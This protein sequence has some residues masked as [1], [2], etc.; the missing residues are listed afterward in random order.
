MSTA[1]YPQGM[2]KYNNN[3]PQGGYRSWKNNFPTGTTNTHIRPLQNK[4]PLNWYPNPFGKPRPLKHYRKGNSSGL[5]DTTRIVR[6]SK[7]QSLE[8][9]LGM[10]G[11]MQGVP[12]NYQ[13]NSKESNCEN[14]NG[15]KIVLTETKELCCN[16]E[17]KALK[18]VIYAN[19]NLNNENYYPN[20]IQY[21]QNKCMTYDKKSFGFFDHNI[22]SSKYTTNCQPYNKGCNSLISNLENNTYSVTEYPMNSNC[23]S[24][25]IAIYKPKNKYFAVQGSVSGST[26]TS[27]LIAETLQSDYQMVY[28]DRLL[29][30][31]DQC[32]IDTNSSCYLSKNN[33]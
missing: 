2:K 22:G 21:L 3:I 18:N 12:A 28:R 15:I 19:Q 6:S 14:C 9:G 27:K 32:K 8:G 4:D 10:L 29:Y 26:R 33:N 20:H 30:T 11:N 5:N 25:N 24:C 13:I 16:K 17:E 31:K 1:F 7:S 23:N